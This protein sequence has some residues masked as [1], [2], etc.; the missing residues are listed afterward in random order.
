MQTQQEPGLTV[1]RASEIALMRLGS[2][3]TL[4]AALVPNVVEPLSGNSLVG[5][6]S[7]WTC[8]DTRQQIRACSLYGSQVLHC[9]F[10]G[11]M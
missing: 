3:S 4:T 7:V 9:Y 10:L 5:P 6:A 8:S 2:C 1:Q 11:L